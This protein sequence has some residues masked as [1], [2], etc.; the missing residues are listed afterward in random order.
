MNSRELQE[1]G[2][3]ISNLQQAL[4]SLENDTEVLKENNVDPSTSDT[5]R[6]QQETV[7]RQLQQLIS[8]GLAVLEKSGES[9]GRELP[10]RGRQPVTS[11]ELPPPRLVEYSGDG[12]PPWANPPSDSG[13]PP[14]NN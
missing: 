4:N 1:L 5:L 2:A 14:S 9:N 12:P 7:Q 8:E 11:G 6:A 10:L 13:G 3:A